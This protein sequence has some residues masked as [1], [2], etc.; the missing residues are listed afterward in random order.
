MVATVSG[1]LPQNGAF[2][3]TTI[4]PSG[5]DLDA[6]PSGELVSAKPGS[7]LSIQNSVA[8]NTLR[9]WQVAMPMPM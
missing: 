2:S 9:S 5:V 1:L 3:E 8:E 6:D 4:L 7:S